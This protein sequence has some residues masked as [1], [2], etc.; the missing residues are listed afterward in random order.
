MLPCYTLPE[1][2]LLCDTC[3]PLGGPYICDL[4]L[5]G[6]KTGIYRVADKCSTD[7]AMPALTLNV[8]EQSY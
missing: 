7:L 4:A 8:I 3:Q 2:D 5:V 1:I 6:L